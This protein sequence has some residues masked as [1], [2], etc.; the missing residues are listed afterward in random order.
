MAEYESYR[1]YHLYHFTLSDI[2]CQSQC[3]LYA[4]NLRKNIHLYK[5]DYVLKIC[6][7]LNNN[8]LIPVM[9]R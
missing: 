1:P 9:M 8:K 3:A 2:I 7:I 6:L 4:Q 5:M